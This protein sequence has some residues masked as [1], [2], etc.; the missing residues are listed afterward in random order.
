MRLNLGEIA[1]SLGC[2]PDRVLW[3]PG[4]AGDEPPILSEEESRSILSLRELSGSRSPGGGWED[5]FDSQPW[6]AIMPTGAQFDSREVT[7]G[8]LFFCLPGEKTD[9]HEFAL[10]AAKAGASAIIALRNPFFG[11][12]DELRYA[13]IGL[14]PVFLVN[15]VKKALWRVAVCHRDT[16][17]ARVVGI[18]GSAGK[19][20]VKEVLAQVMAVR[21]LT[22]RSRKNF[23]NQLGLPVS[24]LN[25]KAD[26]SF[27]IMEAGISEARDMDELGAILHPDLALILNVGHAHVAGLGEKGVAASKAV[28]LDYIQPGGVAVVSMDYP[29]LNAEVDRRLSD[30]ERRS[31]QLV[32][33]TAR[34]GKAAFRARYA[35]PGYDLSGKY[36]VQMQGGAAVVEAPFR[37]DFGSENVAAICAVAHTLGLGQEETV[38]GLACAVG[39]EQRFSGTNMGAFIVVDDSYNANPLSMERMIDAARTLAAENGRP[40]ILVLGEMFELGDESEQAHT[41]LGRQAAAASPACVFWKGEMGAMVKKG[42][43]EGGFAGG[44]YPVGGGQDFSLLLEEIRPAE[45]VILF[46]GSR[47]NRLERLVDVFRDFVLPGGDGHAV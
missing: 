34:G 47:A 14:P 3:E 15:D 36:E 46:K 27:W 37:G 6:A 35:G 19:T 12:E 33:F 24:M 10:E 26:A 31:I 45:G 22:E 2:R 39:V 44:F 32:R 17:V 29:D 40:L 18:T 4:L 30:F 9:G 25:A 41:A 20:T 42:L 43:D 7:K 38:R 23:N 21:G 1:A 5:S 16:S 8:D 28:L 11:R 13:Q